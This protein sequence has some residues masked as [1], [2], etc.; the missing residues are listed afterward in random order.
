M[1]STIVAIGSLEAW[2]GLDE[3]RDEAVTFAVILTSMQGGESRGD[4]QPDDLNFVGGIGKIIAADIE[5][6][7]G[8]NRPLQQPL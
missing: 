3:I 6:G 4:A 5:E 7:D 8:C 1:G 2:Y